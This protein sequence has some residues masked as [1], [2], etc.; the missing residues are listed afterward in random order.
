MQSALDK[1]FANITCAKNLGTIYNTL[2]GSTTEALDLS[3]LLRAEFVLSVS[4][5]DCFIHEIVEI[6]MKEIYLKN[7]AITSKFLSFNVPIGSFWQDSTVLANH[8]WLLEEVRIKHSFKSFQRS[9][10][11]AEAI[12][13]ISNVKIW[14]KVGELTS[15]NAKDVKDRLDL[16]IDRRNKIAHEA[17]A[18][19]TNP[20]ARWSIDSAQVDSV[21]AF[22]EEIAQSIY[23]SL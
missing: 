21:I 14:E 22:I 19:P 12:K 4:A 17:D 8:E 16:I 23:N 20:G 18:D 11:I 7:R 5:L 10:N 9:D 3:D 2:K 13:L 15:Q 6:G 1:F